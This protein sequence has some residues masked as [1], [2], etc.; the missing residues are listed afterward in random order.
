MASMVKNP[1]DFG[2]GL[3]YVAFGAAGA[4]PGGGLLIRRAVAGAAQ[5]A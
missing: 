4:G 3:M 1:K 2:T 5:E